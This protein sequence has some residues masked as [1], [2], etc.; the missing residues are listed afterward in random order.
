MIEC[1]FREFY[2]F[3]TVIPSIKGKKKNG[4]YSS[5]MYPICDYGR[6]KWVVIVHIDVDH[7]KYLNENMSENQIFQQCI[8]FLSQPP[9]RKKYAK[10]KPKPL[11]G[12]LQIYKAK[13]KEDQNGK[14]IEAEII[15]DQRKNK[16][17][18][19]EGPKYKR[20]IKL[21]SQLRSR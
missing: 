7:E 10:K 21:P 14:F 4:F 11:Y 5:G 20:K 6:T 1:R 16:N 2:E 8:N 9:P 3:G 19:R 12:E 17:F 13:F 18:W 15:T